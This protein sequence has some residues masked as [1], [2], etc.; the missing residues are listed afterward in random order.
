MVDS[1]P[2]ATHETELTEPVDL[3]L[4]DG[5][6]LNPAARGW[7]R[8]QLHRANLRG[9]WG[10]TKRWDYWGILTGH[11]FVSLT[12]ADID[13]AALV[14]VEWGDFDTS[15]CGGHAH[16]VPFG[17]GIDL[18]E[19]SG[20]VP[21]RHRSRS[22]DA[23]ITEVEGGTHLE[24]RWR[25]KDGRRGELDVHIAL[26]E[27]HESLNVV[28]PWSETRFQFTSKHQ[29]RPANGA[30]RVGDATQRIGDDA[31]AWATLDVG[32]GRWPY[33]TDW[34]WAGGAGRTT[35]GHTVGI[36][37][38]SKWTDGTGATENG[39]LVDGRLT[40]I[41]EELTWSYSFDRPM[42]TWQVRSADGA[43]DLTLTPR[44]DRA[45]KLSVG[46]LA[47]GGHQVF[48]D[49]SGTVIH[50]DGPPLTLADDVIGFAEEIRSRW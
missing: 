41:G 47:Q 43:L 8:H 4:P 2:M 3:C 44:F 39:I 49:W 11:G 19:R 29:A 26:P 1:T 14:S 9:R 38:G 18:P 24:A 40:K 42:E 36:Q 48:G 16:V 25:E 37:L 23:D 28:V 17:R 15:T 10:R 27:G 21:L 7:S 5:H 12:F 31:A 22:L 33:R 13:Y 45:S 34:N 6:R 30:F 32:R 50:D 35:D 20:D 46:V